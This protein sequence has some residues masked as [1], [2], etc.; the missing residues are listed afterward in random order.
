MSNQFNKID[1][2]AGGGGDGGGDGGGGDGVLADFKGGGMQG[3]RRRG[4]LY[5]LLLHAGIRIKYFF[6]SW[7]LLKPVFASALSAYPSMLRPR[8]IPQV[9]WLTLF[10]VRVLWFVGAIV[11][12][13][14]ILLFVLIKLRVMHALKWL[15]GKLMVS[16]INYLPPRTTYILLGWVSLIITH[17]WNQNKLFLLYVRRT[18]VLIISKVLSKRDAFIL[19]TVLIRTSELSSYTWCSFTIVVGFKLTTGPTLVEYRKLY[20]KL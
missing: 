19:E 18:R 3:H 2:G 13:H 8:G 17:P 14:R 16:Q 6:V 9:D 11:R 12:T 7:F 10:C 5:V 4:H 15:H 20:S 1:V